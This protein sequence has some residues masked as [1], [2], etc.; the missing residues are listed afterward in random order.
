MWRRVL[1]ISGI[2]LWLV[3]LMSIIINYQSLPNHIPSH[4]NF[5]GNPDAWSTKSFIFIV[6]VIGIILWLAIHFFMKSPNVDKYINVPSMNG[7]P[8]QAQIENGKNLIYVI[9]FE[10]MALFT[11]IVIKDIYTALGRPFNVGIAETILILGVFVIT[12]FVFLYKNFKL[13][14]RKE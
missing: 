14:S 8:S 10:M 1:D 4:Y 2:L 9:K 7:K 12:I 11:F 13:D 5:S 6:P 3:A